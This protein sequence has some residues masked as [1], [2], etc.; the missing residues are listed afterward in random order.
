M[1]HTRPL[2]RINYLIFSQKIHVSRIFLPLT[3][4]SQNSLQ[5]QP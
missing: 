4:I 1:T 3:G 2:K 5:I